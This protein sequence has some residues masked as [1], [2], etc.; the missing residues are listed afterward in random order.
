MRRIISGGVDHCLAHSSHP[1][2][3]LHALP[4]CALLSELYAEQK[5]SIETGVAPRVL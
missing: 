3:F 2:K 4:W 1:F 5:E